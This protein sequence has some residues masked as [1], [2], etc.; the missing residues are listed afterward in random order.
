MNVFECK[1]KL[2]ISALKRCKNQ[3]KRLNWWNFRCN[4]NGH[5]Q[6]QHKKYCMTIGKEK[7]YKQQTQSV[8]T[9]LFYSI[10]AQILKKIRGLSLWTKE[11]LCLLQTVLILIISALCLLFR[12]FVTYMMYHVHLRSK[13][14]FFVA[15]KRYI[16]CHIV[17]LKIYKFWF[18]I[19]NLSIWIRVIAAFFLKI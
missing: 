14:L 19:R 5:I 16:I 15:S 13:I 4:S 10:L 12:S 2:R 17:K 6:Y 18:W 11:L 1:L 7:T 3:W 8:V 9:L